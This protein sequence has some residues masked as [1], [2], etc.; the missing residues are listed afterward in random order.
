MVLN[1]EKSWCEVK[2]ETHVLDIIMD[3]CTFG[4]QGSSSCGW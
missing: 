3:G 4:L 2:S 1:K